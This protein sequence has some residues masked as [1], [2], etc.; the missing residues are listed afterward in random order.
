MVRMTGLHPAALSSCAARCVLRTHP[1]RPSQG[2]GWKWISTKW[3]EWDEQRFLELRD[4][5]VGGI[6]MDNKYP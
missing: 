6:L 1:T 2:K 5:M 4:L 3:N